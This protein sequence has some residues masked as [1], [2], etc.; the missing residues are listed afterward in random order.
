MDGMRQITVE[1]ITAG[2]AIVWGLYIGF[3]T[4]SLFD[5]NPD[6]YGPIM[7]LVPSETAWG[8]A[9]FGVGFMALTLNLL[10][11]IRTS[12]LM[13]GLTFGFFASLFWVGDAGSP[14]GSLNTLFAIANL[15]HWYFHR[16]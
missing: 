4:T 2:W 13:V 5:R 10:G 6:L 3:P 1:R 11:H 8:V 16:T 15:S 7:Y 12:A 9:I 14:A